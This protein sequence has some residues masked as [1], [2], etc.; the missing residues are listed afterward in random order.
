MLVACLVTEAS[1]YRLLESERDPSGFLSF[2]FILLPAAAPARF[3]RHVRELGMPPDAAL[4]VLPASLYLVLEE[5]PAPAFVY[6]NDALITAAFRSG[7]ADYLRE[8]WGLVEVYA[9]AI[10]L[11]APR[12]SLCG[13]EITMQGRELATRQTS[14]RLTE[15]EIR[16]LRTLL[17]HRGRSV[18]AAA[19]NTA[20]GA[21]A[22]RR[23]RLGSGANSRVCAV[24]IAN[25]RKKLESLVPGAG[26]ALLSAR[27]EGYRFDVQTCG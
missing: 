19:L 5:R 8:P 10:R 6:G 23:R 4:F 2:L 27:G 15:A 14:V 18:S 20:A 13:A 9:R 11:F 26:A 21:T 12:F 22:N 3:P 24:H 25:L 1:P 17:A 7:C 16:I